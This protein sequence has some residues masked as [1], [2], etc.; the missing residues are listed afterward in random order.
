M[1]HEIMSET[2]TILRR[3]TARINEFNAHCSS[4]HDP[5]YFGQ[6]SPR[7]WSSRGSRVP[8]NISELSLAAHRQRRLCAPVALSPRMEYLE[9]KLMI[10]LHH[11]I[12]L[13]FWK[14]HSHS[15]YWFDGVLDHMTSVSSL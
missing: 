6:L 12:G 5:G 11:S 1:L 7:L 2:S 10:H 14:P 9:I 8:A 4:F 15:P 13:S 3:E